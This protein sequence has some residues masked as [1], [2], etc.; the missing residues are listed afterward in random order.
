MQGQRVS[1]CDAGM[2]PRMLGP[3]GETEAQAKMA[4]PKQGETTHK[5]VDCNMKEKAQ[6]ER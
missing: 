6:A 4:Q 2:L 1:H 5:A 3:V